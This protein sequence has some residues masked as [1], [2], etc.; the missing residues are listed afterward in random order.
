MVSVEFET[1]RQET[2]AGAVSSGFKQMIL[3]ETLAKQGII[4][5]SG[6]TPKSGNWTSGRDERH[7]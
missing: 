3:S 5:K 1:F 2:Q 7:Q 4:A 6:A